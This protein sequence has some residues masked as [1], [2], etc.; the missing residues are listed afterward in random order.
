MLLETVISH[1]AARCGGA[2]KGRQVLA[3]TLGISQAAISQWRHVRGGLVPKLRAMELERLTGG[4][5]R[6]DPSMYDDERAQQ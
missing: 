4:E 1:F 3:E 2:A 6:F 5:L